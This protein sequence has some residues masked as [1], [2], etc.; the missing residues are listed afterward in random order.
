MIT[1]FFVYSIIP[2]AIY[3]LI[4]ALWML[5]KKPLKRIVNYDFLKAG[6]NIRL[7]VW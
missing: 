5:R 3:L 2:W 7:K 1:L 4:Y 6:Y